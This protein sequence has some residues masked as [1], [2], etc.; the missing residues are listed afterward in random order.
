MIPPPPPRLADSRSVQLMTLAASILVL[1]SDLAYVLLIRSQGSG[2]AESFTQ[3]FIAAYVT[4]LAALLIVSLLRLPRPGWR[5]PLR[6]AAAGGLLVLG[7]LAL[8]SV[9]LPLLIAG[10]LTT[11]AT[12]RTL[13][14]P[15]TKATLSAVASAAVAIAVLMSGFAVS[16]R[17][18]TCPPTGSMS[19]GGSGGFLNGPYYYECVD[20]H[21]TYHSG[22]C[23]S[24]AIDQSGHVTHPGC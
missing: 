6:G 24:G 3:P 4:V 7:V 1:A 13:R 21:L 19:G 20:G 11:I 2:P 10:V 22:T 18:I 23:N 5:M 9:G 15:Q 14:V 8:M 16:G 12:V 17:I